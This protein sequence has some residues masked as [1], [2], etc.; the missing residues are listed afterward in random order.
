MLTARDITIATHSTQIPDSASTAASN[1]LSMDTD[2]SARAAVLSVRGVVDMLTTP[3]LAKAIQ[4][5]LADA[6]ASLIVDLSEVELLASV[7]IGALV[8]AQQDVGTVGRFAVVADGPATSRP[9]K[10]LGVDSIVALF[11]TFEEALADVAAMQ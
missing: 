9:I 7:G 10:L 11:P 6:A 4:E 3:Q 5:A 2:W 1:G 8:A